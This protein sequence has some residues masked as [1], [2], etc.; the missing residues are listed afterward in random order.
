LTFQIWDFL[1]GLGI[2][3]LGMHQ[4]EAGLNEFS[5]KTFR[6]LLQKFTDTPIKGIISGT[7]VTALLQSSSLVTLM[8]LA[9]LGAG[10]I[11]FSHAAGVILGANLGTTVTAW[12]VYSLGF[13]VDIASFSLP[14][15]GVGALLFILASR[16][17]ILKNLGSFLLGFGLLFFGIDLMKGSIEYLAENFDF[18]L[19]ADWGLVVFALIGLILTAIIQSSSA[20]L[21]ILLSAIS[22]GILGLDQAAAATVG[23]NIGTTVTVSLGALGGTPDKKRLASLHFLFNVVTG[24]IVLFFIPLII[25]WISSLPIGQDP[26]LDLALFNTILN[27]FGVLLFLPFIKPITKWLKGRFLTKE[28][29]HTLYIQNVDVAVPEA[30][31]QALEKEIEE[32]FVKTKKFISLTIM[33]E[34]IPSPKQG[35]FEKILSRPVEYL[36][37]YQSLKLVEDEITA[38]HLKLLKTSI[39]EE[40]AKKL[41][42]LML[43]VRLMIF[44]AK[45]FKDIHHNIKELRNSSRNLPKDFLEELK[46]KFEE[47]ILEID[48]LAKVEQPEIQVPS[49]MRE[50]ELDS[51]QL[52]EKLFQEAK[53]HKTDIPFSTF[54][55]VAREF[56]RGLYNL[57][58]A[59]LHWRHPINE[60]FDPSEDTKSQ[61]LTLKTPKSP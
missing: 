4:M 32:L 57:G 43:S 47:R 14:L 61:A 22:S 3:L 11:R 20:T 55:N 50:S 33:E 36:G 16:Y 29:P 44:S 23:A 37:L 18:S 13:K 24:L 10:I 49:W 56:S 9:F 48:Q 34:G 25:Q 35:I 7:L 27:A 39:T 54:T 45:D 6:R 15:I 8:V 60:V 1:A 59:V 31:I 28:K 12:L 51:S 19:Y 2:F 40:E 41:T 42:S 53:S 38:Y 30:A 26:L 17:F 52:V 5:G 21:V 58:A 46:V